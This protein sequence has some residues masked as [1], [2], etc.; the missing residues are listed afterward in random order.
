MG[1]GQ[2]MEF[3]IQH[4]VITQILFIKKA[5][6]PVQ[7]AEWQSAAKEKSEWHIHKKL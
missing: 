1:Q 4:V 6:Q 2:V 7:V 5:A 3:L